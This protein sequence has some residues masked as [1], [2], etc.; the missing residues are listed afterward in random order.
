MNISTMT[1]LFYNRREDGSLTPIPEAIA[2]CKAA[3]FEILDLN[4]CPMDVR[5]KQYFCDDDWEE[6][7]ENGAEFI[8]HAD[9]LIEAIR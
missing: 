6:D 9:T 7:A 5:R 8:H 1:S 2:R 3:G 4:M